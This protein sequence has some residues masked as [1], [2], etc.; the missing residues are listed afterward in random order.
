MKLYIQF[1]HDAERERRLWKRLLGTLWLLR[2]WERRAKPG[3][4]IRLNP[5]ILTQT[6]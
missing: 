2:F 5:G 6:K 3:E 1:R 4:L